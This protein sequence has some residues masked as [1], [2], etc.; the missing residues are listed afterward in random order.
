MPIIEYLKTSNDTYT[1]VSADNPL[2]VAM[3]TGDIAIGAVEIKDATTDTRAVVDATYG[4]SVDVKRITPTTLTIA[5]TVA[6]SGVASST[7]LAANASRK[8]ALIVNDSANTI[9]IFLGATAVL[10]QG[11]RLNANGGSYE[12]NSTNL[13]TG[14]ITTITTVASQ[15]VI[16]TEG[17]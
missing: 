4:L 3:S 2:P 16:V 8:Y 10:N 6:T 5:H 17:T 1:E 13:Y 15:N 7:A 12:I 14:I 11:I 9:Y